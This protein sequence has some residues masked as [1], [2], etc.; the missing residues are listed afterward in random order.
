MNNKSSKSINQS[1]MEVKYEKKREYDPFIEVTLQFERAAKYLDIEPWIYQRLKHPE[2]ELSVHIVITRDNGRAESF[3]GF[4]VRHSTIRGPAKGGIRYS[5][6]A[7]IS[8]CKAL[9]AWMT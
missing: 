4:R 6:E 9:A 8:E 2:K 3:T 5:P 7:S 1:H